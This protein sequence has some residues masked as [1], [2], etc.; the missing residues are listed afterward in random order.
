[1]NFLRPRAFVVKLKAYWRWALGSFILIVFTAGYFMLGTAGGSA[2]AAEMLANPLSVF[3]ERSPGFR[4]SGALAQTKLAYAK[5]KSPRREGAARVPNERVLSNLRSRP[6]V[7][8]IASGSDSQI[9]QSISLSALGFPVLPEQLQGSPILFAA[10][11]VIGGT[12]VV[13]LPPGGGAGGT[14]GDS[15]TPA[16][17]VSAVPEPSDWLMVITGFFLIGASLRSHRRRDAK[18]I[19]PGIGAIMIGTRR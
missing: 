11:G 10:P 9:P 6:P 8:P 5:A 14:P 19:A 1:M 15:G 2:L 17:P 3:A 7:P 13:G 12:G 18:I 4:T 16:T